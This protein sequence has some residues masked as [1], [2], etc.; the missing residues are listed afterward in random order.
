MELS[1]GGHALKNNP[2]PEMEDAMIDGWRLR[3]ERRETRIVAK[4]R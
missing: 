4:V 1:C 2:D 3:W